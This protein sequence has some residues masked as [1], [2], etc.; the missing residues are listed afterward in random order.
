MPGREVLRCDASAANARARLLRAGDGFP[1]KAS[2]PKI[3][4]IFYWPKQARSKVAETSKTR[5]DRRTENVRM[6]L[7]DQ[8][9][10]GVS[11]SRRP[12]EIIN[13]AFICS[14][15][16]SA[17]FLFSRVAGRNLRLRTR[18]IPPD[19]GPPHGR[20]P[21]PAAP[22]HKTDRHQGQPHNPCGDHPLLAIGFV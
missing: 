3:G 9:A 17:S 13:V 12:E 22:R 18:S 20:P 19:A 7:Q 14:P 11:N 4:A 21:R 16:V 6:Q 15:G 1:G 10:R 2:S 8:L 5:H